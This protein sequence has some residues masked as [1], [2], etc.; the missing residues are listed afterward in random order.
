MKCDIR[1]Y[2]KGLTTN[3]YCKI[4]NVIK[5]EQCDND[6]IVTCECGD[7]H[8]IPMKCAESIVI[9]N[10]EDNKHE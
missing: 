3:E 2:Y 7:K 5:I 8:C 4:P 6:I 10:R 9:V 1:I